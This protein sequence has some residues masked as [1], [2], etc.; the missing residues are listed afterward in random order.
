MPILRPNNPDD[1]EYGGPTCTHARQGK[2]IYQAIRK[3]A[4]V[5]LARIRFG[6]SGLGSK[7]RTRMRAPEWNEPTVG[8]L[9]AGIVAT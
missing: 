4:M 5:L 3:A 8:S 6:L 1:C 9:T 2:R 7:T